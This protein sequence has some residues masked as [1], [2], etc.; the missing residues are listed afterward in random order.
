VPVGKVQE[1]NTKLQSVGNVRGIMVTRKGYQ[2]GAHKEARFYGINLYTYKYPEEID[3]TGRA[4][5]LV[6][7]IDALTINNIK[8]DFVFDLDPSSK[9]ERVRMM[10]LTSNVFIEDEEGNKI[11]SIQ[12][13]EHKLKLPKEGETGLV[14]NIIFT[15]PIFLSSSKL[16][17]AKI[18]EI[19]FT[20]DVDVSRETIKITADDFV[21]GLLIDEETG[22]SFLHYIDGQL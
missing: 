11:E 22:E 13:A 15:E 20:Y 12:D 1:F 8:R 19:K 2:S 16:S 4:K 10:E 14:Q 5:E 7:Y 6:I 3:W 17:R 18:K 21:R 9:I